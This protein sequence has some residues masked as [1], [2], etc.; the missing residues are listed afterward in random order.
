MYQ[1]DNEA[2]NSFGYSCGQQEEAFT[3]TFCAQVVTGSPAFT[4]GRNGKLQVSQLVCEV[5]WMVKLPYYLFRV[6]TPTKPQQ[7]ARGVERSF[8]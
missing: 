8:K 4:F 5:R 2:Y 6:Y 3:E 1:T 7:E